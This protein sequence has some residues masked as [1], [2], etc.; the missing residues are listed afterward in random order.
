MVKKMTFIEKTFKP[1]VFALAAF[2]CLGQACA[3]PLDLLAF[4]T[5]AGTWSKDS[6]SFVMETRSHGFVF[7]DAERTTA[8]SSKAGELVFGDI[9]VY[10]TRVYWKNGAMSRAEISVYNKGDAVVPID[11]DE[12][13]ALVKKT[14]GLVSGSLGKGMTCPDEKPAPRKIVKSVKWANRSPMALMQ[15]ANEESANQGGRKGTFLAEF[16][17]VTFVPKSGHGAKDNASLTGKSMLVKARNL[18]S[19]SKSVAKTPKG[20]VYIDGMP[21]VDQGAK[22]YC[23]ASTTERVLRYYGLEIDQHQVAQLAETSAAS[24]TS[25]EGIAEAA[26]KIGKSY[27]LVVDVLVKV[28]TKSGSFEKSSTGEELEDYNKAA[29]K[30]HKPKI[31]W[32]D[33]A[34]QTG[35]H[36]MSID[37]ASIFAAMEPDVLLAAKTAKRQQAAAFR[38]D[39]AKYID[40]GVPLIWSCLVGIYPEVPDIPEKGAFGHMRLIIGYNNKTDE[41]I[42]TDSW[43]GAHAFKRMPMNQ[44]WAMTKGLMVLKPR[45]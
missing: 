10:E 6:N 7:T 15:W 35:P 42:Y 45:Y 16:I 31:D 27:S 5:N 26:E 40:K 8:V 13:D 2:A 23:A 37:I 34:K 43:G 17:R 28:D 14:G 29:A 20:D 11:K 30:M 21:M 36:S 44:A 33:H 4:F 24:G 22:G 39:I 1:F 3:E 18:M 19:L 41:V 9:P 38:R 25:F 32:H 12:F